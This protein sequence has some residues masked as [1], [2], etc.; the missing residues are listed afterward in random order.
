MRVH[1]NPL[2]GGDYGGRDYG[3]DVAW[4]S[5]HRRRTL[6]RMVVGGGDLGQQ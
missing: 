4:D 5:T 2:E 1:R 3:V 6:P